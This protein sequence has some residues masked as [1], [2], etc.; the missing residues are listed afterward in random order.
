[1]KIASIIGLVFLLTGHAS[2]QVNA[3]SEKQS[4]SNPNSTTDSNW[5]FR[6]R[7]KAATDIRDRGISG[8]LNRPAAQLTVEILHSSGAFSE[9]E[10][11][12]VSKKQYPGGRGLRLQASGGYRWGDPDAFQYEVGAVGYGY[13]GSSSTGVTGYELV[14]DPETGEVVDVTPQ[15][16]KVKPTTAEL[17]AKVSYQGFSVRY[18]RTISQNFNGISS[19][20]VCASIADIAA[21]YD[22]VQAGN[23]N[24]KGSGY[25]EFEYTW[26]VSKASALT[27]QVGHQKV[28]NFRD[29]DFF[30][31]SVEWKK[32]VS[33]FDFA[34]G[35][36]GAKARNRE[37]YR[38]Q[39]DESKS[40]D[41]AKPTLYLSVAR[42]F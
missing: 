22:C 13:P 42:P 35:I 37:A 23:L 3:N 34:I 19:P 28:R 21:S 24:S 10:A 39:I 16:T 17:F 25:L 14:F 33:Q 15:L 40:R 20:V 29:F 27:F 1:M 32:T 5:N 11:T 7:V 18:L 9:L 38:V 36:A 2:A 4:A 41:T 8:S 6:G 12:T 30:N 31:Y 26:R